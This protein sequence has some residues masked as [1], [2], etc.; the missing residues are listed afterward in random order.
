MA[1]R[2][3]SE[4]GDQS[5]QPLS[6]RDGRQPRTVDVRPSRRPG[7]RFPH[8]PQQLAS[9][10]LVEVDARAGRAP[11]V[12]ASRALSAQ[13]GRALVSVA[14]YGNESA[15]AGTG[16][17]SAADTL[18]MPVAPTVDEAYAFCRR[19][20][21]RYGANF[22]VGFRFL[23]R[24]KRRAVYAAYAFCRWADDIADEPP[25]LSRESG[26]GPAAQERG[27]S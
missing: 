17:M 24:R 13:A 22:S 14:R 2:A 8:V 15:A 21:H 11:S 19:I 18:P 26:E 9:G 12:A 5:G 10:K 6:V 7:Q 23:P 1:E 20:A 16:L 3:R 25:V 27:G 4:A